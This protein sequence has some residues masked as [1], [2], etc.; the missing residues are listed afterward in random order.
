MSLTPPSSHGGGGLNGVTLTGTPSAGQTIVATSPTAADWE[1]PPGAS[2]ATLQGSVG[3][4]TSLGTFSSLQDTAPLGGDHIGAMTVQGPPLIVA[5][6]SGFG[7][8]DVYPSNVP[9]ISDNIDTNAT[10]YITDAAG[11]NT[12]T[13]SGSSSLATPV[14]GD[15]TAIDWTAA[16]AT[17]VGVDLTWDG[18]TGVTST[19]GGIYF[20]TLLVACSPD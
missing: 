1:S 9:D 8:P 11:A 19:A 10:L 16:S 3:I 20:V 5:A 15:G 6:A 13:V 12:L 2:V 14:V 18:T 7:V 17:I 4:P